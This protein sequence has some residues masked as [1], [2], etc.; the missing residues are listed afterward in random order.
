MNHEIPQDPP[1]KSVKKPELQ[2]HQ[3][4]N[5]QDPSYV[6]PTT[7]IWKKTAQTPANQQRYDQQTLQIEVINSCN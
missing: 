3:R 2:T 4:I 7:E 5:E 1:K 6:R